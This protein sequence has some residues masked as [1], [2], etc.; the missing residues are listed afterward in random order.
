M[1]KTNKNF[2]KQSQQVNYLSKDFDQFEQSLLD[3]A[4]TYFPNTFKDFSPT[5][6]GMLYIKLAAYVGDV[7]SF[8]TDYNFKESLLP[9]AQERKNVLALAKSMG[10][11]P[12]ITRPSF[13][14]IEVFQIVPSIVVDGKSIPDERFSLILL[15]DMEVST[16]NGES[17]ITRELVDFSTDNEDS[18]REVTAFSRDSLGQVQTFLVKKTAKAQSG[19]IVTKLFSIGSAQE[20]LRLS[21]DEDDVIEILNV[22][23]ADGNKWH[24]VDYLSQDIVYT[25]IENI[26]RNDGKLFKYRESVPSLIGSLRTNRKYITGITTENQTFLEFGSGINSS[27][28]DQ[29]ILDIKNVQRNRSNSLNISVDPSKFLQSQNYG[30]APSNTTIT[31][32]Y[33]V[34]GGITS[35]V[36]ANEINSISRVEFSQQLDDFK[37]TE[38]EL[39]QSLRNS[40]RVTNPEPATGGGNGESTE[41]IRQNA[42]AFFNSQ[43]RV[44]TTNDY[45]ARIMSMPS[46]FGSIAKVHVTTDNE[47]SQNAV[48]SDPNLDKSFD[49]NVYSLSYN[50]RKHL[51]NMN[52]ALRQ[53]II[54]HLSRYRML[55]DEI[56][57][58]DGFIVNIG[59]NFEITTFKG[60][61]KREVLARC[62]LEAKDFFDIDN[63]NFNQ[64][65]NISKFELT[66]ANVQGVQ[67]VQNVEIRNL[68]K[69]NG[70]YSS[71]EYNIEKATIDKIIYPSLDPSIFEV[72][73]PNKDIT[74]KVL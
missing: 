50:N 25:E 13:V 4:K 19:R 51:V 74:G 9:F 37:E 3:Y 30:L 66:L 7:L 10:Y 56:K 54:R 52:P 26:Q 33:I 63:M 11:K 27:E 1:K 35:N 70:D 57:I 73:Y 41:E 23:D 8:Y 53:N 48:N 45:T 5:S 59:V 21:L 42:L 22:T 38:R 69:T 17:F 12:K 47:I 36:N 18:P 2:S 40:L 62:L 14:E 43:N 67:S 24:E 16:P 34:G 72:K 60:E 55:T 61:N 15:P 20:F 32:E 46:K 28:E 64:A 58:L 49:V 44:V 68:S 29:I 31:V 71:V 6:P 39:V 65:I